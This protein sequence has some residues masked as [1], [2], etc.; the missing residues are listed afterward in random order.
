MVFK[1]HGLASGN[2]KYFGII[3]LRVFIV[4]HIR[5]DIT[6]CEKIINN[7]ASK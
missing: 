4:K 3:L 6:V 7:G 1:D 2:E 5:D